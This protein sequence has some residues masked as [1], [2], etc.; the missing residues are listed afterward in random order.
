M[1][2]GTSKIP[3]TLL[4]P[5]RNWN[6]QSADYWA[7]DI[8]LPFIEHVT[9][10]LAQCQNLSSLLAH[11]LMIHLSTTLLHRYYF[12]PHFKDEK[13]DSYGSQAANVTEL[14]FK[15]RKT[16]SGAQGPTFHPFSHHF[17]MFFCIFM[18]EGEGQDI[19]MEIHRVLPHI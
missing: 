17:K 12:H 7:D 2:Q 10:F 13:T 15:P 11:S 18:T 19:L 5:L 16:D 14:G 8:R 1:I 9:V 3:P 4:G 6:Q